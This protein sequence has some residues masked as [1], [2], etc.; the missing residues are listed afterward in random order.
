MIEKIIQNF[1]DSIAIKR[2]SAE[3]L[4][5]TIANAAMLMAKAL[6]NNHKILS[7]GNGGSASDAQHFSSEMVNR[8]EMDRPGLPA[9]ALTTDTSILTSI[10]NDYHYDEVFSRQIKALGQ[11]GDILL[12]ISTSGHSKNIIQAINAGHDKALSII[13]L[14]GKDG[15]KIGSMLEGED[16]EIRVPSQCT[17]RIQETHI[18]IIHCLCDMVDRILFGDEVCKMVDRILLNSRNKK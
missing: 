10:S 1:H 4:P 5:G 3:L 11:P 6:D 18:L 17:A 13:A 9:I 2:L 12:V 16:I 14:T 7:C 15:G 8:F